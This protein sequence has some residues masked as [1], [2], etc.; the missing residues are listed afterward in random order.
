MVRDSAPLRAFFERYNALDRAL[1]GTAS[2]G[3]LVVHNSDGAGSRR[4]SRNAYIRYDGAI[5]IWC[6]EWRLAHADPDSCVRALAAR[7][8]PALCGGSGR[9]ELYITTA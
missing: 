3:P 4:A 6:D 5:L 2:S 8:T 7:E 1:C 9:A